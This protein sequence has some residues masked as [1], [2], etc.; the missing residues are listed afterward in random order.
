MRTLLIDNYDSYTYN[1]YQMI[2]DITEKEV[3]VIKK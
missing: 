1:L 2:A 3:L